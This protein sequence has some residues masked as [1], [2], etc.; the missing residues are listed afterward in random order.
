[1][2]QGIYSIKDLEKLTGIKA[3]TIRIWEKRYEV[4]KPSRTNTNIRYYCDDDLKKLLNISVLLKHGLKISHLAELSDIELGEKVINLSY[5]SSSYDTQ[6]DSLISAMISLDDAKFDKTITTA[7]L[8]IGFENAIIKIIYPFLERIGILWQTGS[9][10]AAQE[11]FVSN[12]LRQKMLVAIDNQ[13]GR[14]TKNAAR[15]LLFLPENEFHELGLLFY[16]YLVRKN[17]H[18]IIYLGQSVPFDDLIEVS[19][20][21]MPDV[22]LTYFTYARPIEE[23]IEYIDKLSSSFPDQ[24]IYI[25]GHQVRE[26]VANLPENVKKLNS[27]L[28]FN[29]EL[30]N[31]F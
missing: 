4:V 28:E 12:I 14:P 22:L 2:T 19:K 1:M 27:V 26:L 31:N 8:R 29:D 6:I 30:Q 13:V 15:F 23:L 21:K 16:S 24:Q 25:T 17:G 3:H 9:I 5:Q 18:K 10:N 7:T 11:H 20:Y